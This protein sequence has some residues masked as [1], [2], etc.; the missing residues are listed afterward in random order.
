MKFKIQDPRLVHEFKSVGIVNDPN[1]SWN[2]VMICFDCYFN[3]EGGRFLY[4]VQELIN[5]CNMWSAIPNQPF[6]YFKWKE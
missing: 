3:R 4:I 6:L 2:L 5:K 1:L